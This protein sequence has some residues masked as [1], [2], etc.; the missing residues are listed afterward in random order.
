MN[1][2]LLN[3]GAEIGADVVICGSV[4]AGLIQLRHIRAGNQLQALLSLE[5]DFRAPEL[6][7]ALTYVQEQLPQRLGGTGLPEG[8]REIGFIDPVRHP[9]MVACNWLNEMGTLLKRGPRSEDTF[10]DLFARLDRPLLAARSRRRSRSCAASGARRSTTISNISARAR[11][12]GSSATLKECF[13]AIFRDHCPIDGGNRPKR[14]GGKAD[15]STDCTRLMSQAVDNV[16]RAAC[17]KPLEKS[18]R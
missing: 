6:Q 8:A 7:S 14:G 3:F 9:E 4:I 17:R 18:A 1:P 15:F 5:H 11:W 12:L 10:M 13:H 16:E 2:E